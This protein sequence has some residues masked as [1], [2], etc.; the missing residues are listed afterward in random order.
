MCMKLNANVV[1]FKNAQS[2]KRTKIYKVLWLSP[3][4]C[5]YNVYTHNSEETEYVI[6]QVSISNRDS[7][8]LTKKEKK[9]GDVDYGFHCYVTLYGAKMELRYWLRQD[10]RK[11][12]DRNG[13]SKKGSYHIYECEVSPEFH[14]ADGQYDG[15]K[16]AIYHQIK[17]VR[18][19]QL[20]KPLG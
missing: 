4:G 1:P 15:Y 17:P 8:I 12:D 6:G 20:L 18:K 16:N 19:I 5:M 14:V 7:A 3:S 11:G 13:K 9:A 10:T 2:K